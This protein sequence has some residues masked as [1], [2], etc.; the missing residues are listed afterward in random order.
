M[1]RTAFEKDPFSKP[2]LT[3]CMALI[4]GA[5]SRGASTSSSC[6]GRLAKANANTIL[7]NEEKALT[8]K[9]V[10]PRSLLSLLVAPPWRLL[11]PS[12]Q[13]VKNELADCH[14]DTGLHGCVVELHKNKSCN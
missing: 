10:V 5:L 9:A 11:H 3:I 12:W 4:R 13:P 2:S 6:Q 1:E 7:P 8:L 14:F